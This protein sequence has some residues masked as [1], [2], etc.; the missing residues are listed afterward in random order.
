[1]N[2]GL[3]NSFWMWSG[4]IPSEQLEK[5]YKAYHFGTLNKGANWEPFRGRRM[6][7]RGRASH[8][9]IYR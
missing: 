3:G 7:A 5:I 1:M 6:P 2:Q 8:N 9:I 4:H